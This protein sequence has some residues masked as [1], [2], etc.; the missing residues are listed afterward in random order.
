MLP[1]IEFIYLLLILFK[2]FISFFV[3]NSFSSSFSLIEFNKLI[4]IFSNFSILN[5]FSYM[6]LWIKKLVSILWKI[7]SFSGIFVFSFIILFINS[8]NSFSNFSLF[9]SSSFWVLLLLLL[10]NCSICSLFSF[11]LFIYNSLL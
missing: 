7:F 3:F 9:F 4:I 5:K 6:F 11:I 10:N 8:F 2:G 1:V